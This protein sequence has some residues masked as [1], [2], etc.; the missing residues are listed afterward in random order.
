MKGHMNTQIGEVLIDNDVLA[1]YAGS[2]AVECFGVVGMASVNM[3]DGLVKLLKR[4]SLSH[5]VNITVENNKIIIDLHIIVSYGVSIS[6]VAENLISN[7][8]YKVEEFTGMEVVKINIF[9]EGVRV[10]D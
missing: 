1:K 4:E 9:V 5:G 2:S 6:A 3:K 10:I 7:V 8:K